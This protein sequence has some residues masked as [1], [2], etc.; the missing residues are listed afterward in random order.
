[1]SNQ[2]IWA[3]DTVGTWHRFS[4]GGVADCGYRT[5]GCMVDG[6]RPSRPGGEERVCP[7]CADGPK[8]ARD[9]GVCDDCAR[10]AVCAVVL[11]APKEMNLVISQCAARIPWSAVR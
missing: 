10:A 2:P 8:E 5:N 3:L 1:M 11:T 7:A 9:Q 4:E 6:P